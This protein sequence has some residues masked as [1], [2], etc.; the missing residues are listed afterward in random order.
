M[1]KDPLEKGSDSEDNPKTIHTHLA[2]TLTL[3]LTLTLILI[4]TLI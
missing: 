3:T 4:L 2:L 1:Y